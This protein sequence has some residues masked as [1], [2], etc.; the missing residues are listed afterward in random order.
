MSL[1]RK[2]AAVLFDEKIRKATI[3][4]MVG[5]MA[6]SQKDR[7][8]YIASFQDLLVKLDGK[9]TDDEA[10]YLKA[11]IIVL[12]DPNRM[13]DADD[14]V[15]ASFAGDWRTILEVVNHKLTANAA[16]KSVSLEARE[17]VM[18]NTIAVLTN[19]PE[20]KADWLTALEGLEQDARS[21]DLPEF[22]QYAGVLIQLVKGASPTDLRSG[23]PP[24]FMGDWEKITSSMN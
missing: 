15:P 4:G 5:A 19:S 12:S 3:Q 1:G 20:R 13:T 10:N 6:G 9:L 2:E 21:N 18:H 11:L 24:M 22:E 17:Q 7:D 8:E 16:G 14:N 23:I